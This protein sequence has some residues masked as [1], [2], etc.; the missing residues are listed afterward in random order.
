MAF[1]SSLTVDISKEASAKRV[2]GI[3]APSQ[4][5]SLLTSLKHQESDKGI[6]EHRSEPDMHQF[7]GTFFQ[8]MCEWNFSTMVDI[9]Y[10]PNDKHIEC[11]VSCLVFPQILP[12]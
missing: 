9:K 6:I 7:L 5:R 2:I 12:V 4:L 10:H 3:F 11:L 8:D 1:K